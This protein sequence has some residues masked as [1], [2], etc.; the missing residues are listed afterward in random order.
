MSGST[1]KKL[2]KYL[3]KNTTEVLVIIRN[4]FG[5]RTE[6]M[7]TRQIYQNTKRLYNAGKIKLN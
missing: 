1:V 7:G 6:N 3:K 5:E 4:E 2:K